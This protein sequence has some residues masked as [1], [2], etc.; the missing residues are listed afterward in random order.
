MKDLSSKNEFLW[1]RSK[2]MNRRYLMQEMYQNYVE[3]DKAWD[4]PRVCFLY[5]IGLIYLM[6]VLLYLG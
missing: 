2:F 4:L 6:H 5:S 3:G 1:D